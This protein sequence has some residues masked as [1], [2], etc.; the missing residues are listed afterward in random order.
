MTDKTFVKR[1]TAV[2][3]ILAVLILLMAGMGVAESVSLTIDG[4]EDL[5]P[6]E[7]I[8]PENG[9]MELLEIGRAHV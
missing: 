3:M 8:A 5:Y 7:P 6:V 4:V 9:T 2:G 1:I